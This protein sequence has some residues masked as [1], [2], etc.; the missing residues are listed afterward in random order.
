MLIFGTLMTQLLLKLWFLLQVA[1]FLDTGLVIK[2][3]KIMTTTTC[4]RHG[5]RFSLIV[6]QILAIA[7]SSNLVREVKD[8]FPNF[9]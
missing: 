2:M 5:S 6:E 3:Y 9:K 4:D 1:F 7:L 8:L